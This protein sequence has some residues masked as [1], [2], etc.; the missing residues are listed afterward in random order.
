MQDSHVDH[1]DW[2]FSTIEYHI[3]DHC[4]L[5]CAS[6][7]HFAPL[8]SEHYCDIETFRKDLIRI[9]E[10]IKS[11]RFYIRILGGEPLLH[12]DVLEFLKVAKSI[13]SRCSLTLITNGLLLPQQSQEFFDTLDDL[14][15]ELEW[16]KY[17]PNTQIESIVKQKS[18]RPYIYDHTNLTYS[19]LDFNS[20]YTDQFLFDHC[21]VGNVPTI[22]DG[23]LYKCNFVAWLPFLLDYFNLNYPENYD[24]ESARVN[25][26]D[27]KV[28]QETLDAFLRVPCD[29]CKYCIQYDDNLYQTI[30]WRASKRELN[31]WLRDTNVQRLAKK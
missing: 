20:T 13:F 14:N 12:P 3:T 28:T 7:F 26:F 17:R 18:A 15:V 29:F 1:S 27:E 22:K 25:L 11:E 9:K 2:S 16:S 5:N 8:A 31:E 19:Y 23:Y 10:I 30:P 4:N 21:A 24:I 6:C